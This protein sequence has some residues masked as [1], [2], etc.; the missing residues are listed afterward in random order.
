MTRS[1]KLVGLTAL[2]LV[3]DAGASRADDVER[4]IYVPRGWEGAYEFGYAPVLRVG[5]TVIVSGVP[6]SGEG[7]YEEKVRRMYEKAQELLASA[8]ATFD[9]VVE[10]TTF[11]LEPKGSPAFRAEFER[12]MPIHK[13]FFGEHRP[14]WT[15]VGTSALLS[16]TAVVEMRVLAVAG[17]GR[18]SRVVREAPEAED[19][20][21]DEPEAS[22]AAAGG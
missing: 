9:D 20:S 6:A 8:G 14:A 17:S 19:P 22:D 11:H 12:Y 2:I 13:E 5:N 7:T 10:L 1:W 15:A 18:A 21:G 16:P 4:T 3:L